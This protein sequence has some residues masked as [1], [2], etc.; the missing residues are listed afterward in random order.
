MKFIS[1]RQWFIWKKQLKLQGAI[2]CNTDTLDGFPYL[3][4]SNCMSGWDWAPKLP[5]MGLFRDVYLIGINRDS[6]YWMCLCVEAS[7]V[8]VSFILMSIHAK[9]RM[10]PALNTK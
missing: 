5:D 9:R 7:M 10:A 4:K 1:I 2:P 8:E 3:R 6:E